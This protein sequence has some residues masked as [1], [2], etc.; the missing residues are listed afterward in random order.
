MKAAEEKEK[1]RPTF[2][3]QSNA[4]PLFD[5]PV[6]EFRKKKWDDIIISFHG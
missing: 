4:P 6:C 3:Y 2:C 1:A 5:S